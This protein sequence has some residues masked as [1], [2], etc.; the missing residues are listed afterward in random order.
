MLHLQ[1]HDSIGGL[2]NLRP[3]LHSAMVTPAA[4]PE[5]RDFFE[6]LEQLP[7]RSVTSRLQTLQIISGHWKQRGAPAQFSN[8]V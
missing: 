5:Y 8:R 3:Q 2:V 4:V 1:A 6:G 7:P